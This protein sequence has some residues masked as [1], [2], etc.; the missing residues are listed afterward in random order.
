M[1]VKVQDPDSP[2]AFYIGFNH[3]VKHNAN[4]N[5]SGNLVTIQQYNRGTGSGYG[6]SLLIGKIGTSSGVWSQTL[7]PNTVTVEV[8]AIDTNADT[9]YADVVISYGA[10][11][12]TVSP[13]PQPTKGT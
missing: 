7:G 12:P 8:K 4:S 1:I 6:A 3:K 10:V 5:E 11:V 13:T 2:N 9:G